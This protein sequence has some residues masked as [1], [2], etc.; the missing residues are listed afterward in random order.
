M[1]EHSDVVNAESEKRCNGAARCGAEA[2][3][4]GSQVWPEVAGCAT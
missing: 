3:H 4:G 1:R 2:D